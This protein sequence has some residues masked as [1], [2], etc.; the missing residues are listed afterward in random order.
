[1]IYKKDE[2]LKATIDYFKGDTLAAEVWVNKYALQDLDGNLLEKTPD[3]M[4]RR[5][6]KE[7]ARIE[8]KY[9]FPL[10]EKV[11]YESLKDFKRLV[12]QG[13]P[14][15]GI[16]NPYQ[17][18][19]LSNCFVIGNNQDS[20]GGI[21]KVDEELA[22]L[23]KR[24][25]GV[26][27]DI[28]FI[29]PN[30]TKVNNAAKSSTGVVPY[31]ER[32]SNTTREVAQGGRRGALMLTIDV[33]HPDVEKFIDAKL[34]T[35]KITGANISVKITD[36]FMEKIK[37]G[38]TYSNK[39]WKKI[40]TNAW[41][42]AEPGV[43][44]WDKLRSESIPSC[45]GKDWEETSTNP[46]S[47]LPLCPYDSCRLLAINL[48]GYIDNPFTK[49]ASF[50]KVNFTR[51]THIAM[52][53]MDD[54][55][56]LELEKIDVILEKIHSDPE[57]RRI[58]RAEIELW[59]NIRAKAIQGRRTGL[60]VTGLGDMLAA[61]GLTYGSSKATEFVDQL[62]KIFKTEAYRKSEQLGAIRGPFPIYDLRNEV[63]NPFLSRLRKDK[64][65]WMPRRNIALLTVAPTGSVSIL[66]QTTSGIE[67]VFKP[68]Y[69]RRRKLNAE[70]VGNVVPDFVDDSGD[71]WLEYNVNHYHFNTWMEVNGYSTEDSNID[72]LV[73]LSPYHLATSDTIDW[74]A[75]V[76]MQGVIQK[77]IDHSISVTVNVP[78]N[79]PVSVIDTIYFTA[80]EAGCKGV[81]V[82]REGSRSG[83]LVSNKPTI[84]E[85]HAPKRPKVLEAD[86]IHF[87]NNNE[88]WVAFVGLLNNKP[89]ELFVGLEDAVD[90]P[91]T[92]K[93]GVIEKYK[94][95]EG[96]RYRFKSDTGKVVDSLG[97]VFNEAYWNYA[98]LISGFLRHGM[99]IEYVYHT[100]NSLK[101]NDDFIGTW[102][103]G[104]SRVIKKYM[105]SNTKIEEV[106]GACGSPD[107]EF[108][109]GCLVCRECGASKC[110]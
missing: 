4:H 30:G 72:D 68:Y 8:Q 22:Q 85:N 76:E 13:S 73:K 15:A 58:K 109:E 80:W 10:S 47:E 45:Y 108:S 77:H 62:F 18:T 14:M 5:L 94:T 31:M 56:D 1:M 25:C 52:S 96:N 91:K 57:P 105:T 100:V 51:D 17:L 63:G 9:K 79:T 90:I 99:P 95:P 39:L 86:V 66:T 32:Y 16:G 84:K 11:I 7:L 103:N 41:K 48:Y 55:V 110:S 71:G 87:Q 70:E 81:T 49:E 92:I 35:S 29:R 27:V 104:I 26:G 12:P 78:E 6:A 21:C 89:Y 60:G 106:C 101:L 74:E 40:V 38:D 23:M 75:K 50:N 24:R 36:E 82:Y 102:K 65:Y 97:G 61:L 3:D 64:R 53:L 54:I 28:S 107:I 19:S 98:K 33:D 59:D 44:F 93:S 2:V 42:S 34:D 88:K 83:V 20:Y 67:P 69:T 46:C 43:I 37:E